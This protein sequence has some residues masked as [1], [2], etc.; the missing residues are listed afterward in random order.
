MWE[1]RD[2]GKISG[3]AEELS[4]LLRASNGEFEVFINDAERLKFADVTNRNGEVTIINRRMFR[5]QKERDNT[6]LRVQRFRSNKDSN[7]T[8][9]DNITVPSSSSSSSSTAKIN[10][11]EH[12]DALFNLPEKEEIEQ[13]SDPMIL[14]KLEETCGKLYEDKIFP[15]VFAFKNKMLKEKRNPRAILH[16][17]CRAALKKEF[18]D[19]PWAY[20]LKIIRVEGSNY[21]ERDYGKT[22]S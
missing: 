15:E 12:A 17:L 3:T 18:E 11:K 7:A 1:G 20:C 2:R 14:E 13:G 19:G 10:I 4:R 9:N 8:S 5:E 16:T 22:S 21:N 6:R